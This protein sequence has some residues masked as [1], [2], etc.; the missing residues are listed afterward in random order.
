MTDRET[1][2]RDLAEIEASLRAENEALR[3]R[4]K[5]LELIV[6]AWNEAAEKVP[7]GPMAE[8]LKGSRLLPPD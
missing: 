7:A 3:Q 5:D 2:N 1:D 8:I 4:V 6:D